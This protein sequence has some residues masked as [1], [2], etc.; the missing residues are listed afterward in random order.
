MSRIDVM[1][2]IETLGTKI[3]S[4]ILQISAIAFDIESGRHISQ[5]NQIADISKN[6]DM[7][8]DGATI[9]WW[10]NTDKD[11][12]HLLVNAGTIS[13][14][15]IVENFYNWITQAFFS[16]LENRENVYLWGNGILFDNKIIQHQ[17]NAIGLKYPIYYRNDRDVRTIVELASKKLKI[18][19]S[20]LKEKFDDKSLI[21]HNALD[22]VKYQINLVVG[23]YNTLINQ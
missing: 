7:N 10:L 11:L 15:E 20:K 23:C 13:S 8:V 22:D 16:R 1:V 14:D 9:K 21:K 4:T 3:D 12:L 2:D 19:E 5:F 6:A 18:S 17:M